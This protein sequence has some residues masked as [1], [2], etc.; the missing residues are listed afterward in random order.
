MLADYAQ[1]R[2]RNANP[3]LLPSAPSRAS[4]DLPAGSITLDEHESKALI[5]RFG[6]PVTRD[7]LLAADRLEAPAA[8]ATFPVAAKVL[9]RDIA[10]KT[11]IGA[12][13]LGVRDATEL[14]SVAQELVAKARNACPEATI[15]GV[16][17]CEMVYDALETIVGVV[18]D[19]VFG[20]VVVLGLGGIFAESMRD[21]TF[22]LAPFGAETAREMIAELRGYKLFEAS[23]GKP[24][25][26]VDALAATLSRV[27]VMA[28]TL[29]ER[30]SEVD[31]NPLLVRED[32]HGVVAA[33]A[34][35]ILRAS[36]DTNTP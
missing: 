19:A 13:K 33:D 10:H 18:N 5:S 34:L 24:A 11:D 22:R 7:V 16:L 15:T 23:R 6:V 9:S 14:A 25:R 8:G 27:S 30:I 28:S 3:G 1:S 29:R 2:A 36:S 31:I 20:P 4:L 35:V 32:G 21:V 12:V 17:A 26:D